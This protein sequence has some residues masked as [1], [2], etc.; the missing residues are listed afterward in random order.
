MITFKSPK[1]ICIHQFVPASQARFCV[2]LPE[3]NQA[4]QFIQQSK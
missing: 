2:A 3:V 4:Q 1:K